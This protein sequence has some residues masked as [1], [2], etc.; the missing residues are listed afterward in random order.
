MCAAFASAKT[1][2]ARED[3]GKRIK[4][5]GVPALPLDSA[6]YMHAE[7]HSVGTSSQGLFKELGK[8]YLAMSPATFKRWLAHV[9]SIL[10]WPIEMYVLALRVFP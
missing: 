9:S 10:G 4:R 7:M 5:R 8:L 2:K 1:A 6:Q 3:V